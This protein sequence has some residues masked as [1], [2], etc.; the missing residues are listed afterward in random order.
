M[1]TARC[2]LATTLSQLK[3][4][5]AI[6]FV[7]TY[8]FY[9]NDVCS[10]PLPIVAVKTSAQQTK[11]KPSPYDLV[12]VQLKTGADHDKFSELLTSVNGSVIKTISFGTNLQFFVV[13][14]EHN[15]ARQTVR[16]FQQNDLVTHVD[17]NQTCFA[18]NEIA[19]AL[20][21]LETHESIGHGHSIVHSHS[22]GHGHSS[23]HGHS[24]GHGHSSGHGHALPSGHAHNTVSAPPPPPFPFNESPLPS[25]SNDPYYPTQWDLSVLNFGGARKLGLNHDTSLAFYVLDSGVQ[26]IPGELTNA[27]TYQYD[28]SDPVNPTGAPETVH[29]AAHHGTWVSTVTATTDNSTGYAGAANIEG[30]RISLVMCRI[31]NDGHTTGFV[32]II[33]ALSFI[34]NHAQTPG[35]I[36]L[37]YGF[38]PPTSINANSAVQQVAQYLQQRG[39]L[40]VLAA[41]NSSIVDTSPELY[42]RRVAAI[43]QSGDIASFS[44]TGPFFAAAPGADIPLYMAGEGL[45]Q[46]QESGTSFAAPRWCSAILNVMG[47]LSP[48]TR[49]ATNAESYVKQTATVNSQGYRIPN[50]GAALQAAAGH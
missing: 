10:S 8:I 41:G 1:K 24:I 36:N 40:L 9:P 30:S 43:D 16:K 28:F 6:V 45:T 50:F 22:I 27:S 14:C 18:Q 32:N 47:V 33:D 39:F 17:F 34:Y 12:I 48:Q 15:Q 23:G 44:N 19:S 4:I 38:P 13:Q 25:A 29:D 49:T 20:P 35:P 3:I 37:S 7:F 5:A 2:C 26:P 11:V 42:I 21:R 46:I 31:S